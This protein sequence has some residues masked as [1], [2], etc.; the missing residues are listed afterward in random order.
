LTEK[1]RESSAISNGLLK[2]YSFVPDTHCYKKGP[3]EAYI[4]TAEL[5]NHDILSVMGG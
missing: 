2:M 3:T 5:L 4:A 1:F